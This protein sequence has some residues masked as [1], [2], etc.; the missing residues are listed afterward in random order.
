MCLNDVWGV[1]VYTG[2]YG[3]GKTFTL[4]KA[5]E[6]LLNETD[7]RI[8]V[9]THSNSA[10]DLYIKGKQMRQWRRQKSAKFLLVK[11]SVR[12]AGINGTGTIPSFGNISYIS[13][14]ILFLHNENRKSTVLYIAYAFCLKIA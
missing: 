3:T 2:P 4:G 5:I 14:I 9:C 6:L 7:S 11:S 13:Q 10:A 12:N 8:L 1:V